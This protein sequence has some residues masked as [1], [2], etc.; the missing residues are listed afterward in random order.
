MYVLCLF[1]LLI[2]K[3]DEQHRQT[4]IK[5]TFYVLGHHYQHITVTHYN[6]NGNYNIYIYIFVSIVANYRLK[7]PRKSPKN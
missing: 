2:S 5:G 7:R 1:A 4:T 3:H 6:Y